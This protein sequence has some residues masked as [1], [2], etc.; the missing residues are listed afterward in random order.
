MYVS[1]DQSFD[2]IRFRTCVPASIM[3][4]SIPFKAKYQLVLSWHIGDIHII[5]PQAIKYVKFQVHMAIIM[6]NDNENN[7]TSVNWNYIVNQEARTVDNDADL[8]K[9]KG[10][11]DQFIV[12]E[13][14]AINKEKFY[15]PKSLLKNYDGEILYFNLTE[16]EAKDAFMRDAPPSDE[17]IKYLQSITERL[18]ASRK[19]LAERLVAAAKVD[20]EEEIIAGEASPRKKERLVKMKQEQQQLQQQENEQQLNADRKYNN[21]KVAGVIKKG[22][23]LKENL[24]ATAASATKHI[25]MP[26]YREEE[27]I[28]KMKLAA[29]E[30]RDIVVFGAK[31]AKSGA[32]A[33]KQKIEEK[34]EL[35][36]EKLAQKD[37]EKISKMGGLARQLTNSFDNIL[38]EIETKSY[39]EQEQIYKGL[40]K[41]MNQQHKLIKARRD[42]ATKLK[43]SDKPDVNENRKEAKEHSIV[44]RNGEDQK[45]L[46]K[47]P[48]LPMPEPQLPEINIENTTNV[49]NNDDEQQL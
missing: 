5:V 42:L 44:G 18:V 8:G 31:A 41:L 26:K 3:Y 1:S 16:Q 27:I 39:A 19:D 46:P 21:N 45:Q 2:I 11:F 24:A 25:S 36:A 15:L 10:L 9:I 20:N 4:I 23:E 49:N 17:E 13:R 40:L 43:G 14:G 33:A 47:E 34:Q 30:F 6:Q 48:E 7:N 37:A 38:F 29:S 28:K 12:S 35:E 32:K 22:G